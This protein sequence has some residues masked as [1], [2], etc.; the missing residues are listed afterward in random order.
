MP[1]DEIIVYLFRTITRLIAEYKSRTWPV[2]E[3]K[4]KQAA[5]APSIYPIAKVFYGY[6]V[7]GQAYSGTAK[8]GFWLNNSARRYIDRFTPA[9]RLAVRYNPKQPSASVLRASDQS[10]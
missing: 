3:A 5:S 10:I 9:R 2:A 6:A 8:R 7:D 1:L 4:V